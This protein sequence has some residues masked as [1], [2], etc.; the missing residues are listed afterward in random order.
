MRLRDRVAAIAGGGSGI[1][2]AC[3]LAFAREGANLAI[4]D[5]DEDSAAQVVA[6]VEALGRRAVARRLDVREPDQLAAFVEAAARQLGGLHVWVG[7]A[8]RTLGSTVLE[9]T[10]EDWR[11]L[12]CVNLDGVFFGA[13]AAARHMVEHG[14]GS[15]INL[16]SMYGLRAVPLR[17]AYC[18]SKAAVIMATQ[19]LAVELAEQKVRVNSIAPGYTDTPMLRG[20]LDRQARQVDQLLARVPMGRLASAEE[21]ADV[22]V[23]LAADESRFV[24][25][26]C[27]VADGAWAVAGG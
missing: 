6:E 9:Q 21:I 25:G 16:T 27:P 23:F 4:G 1:G 18:T 19:C 22:A 17:V 24:T 15:I 3:A 26:H 12:M 20:G 10:A 8:G 13:Q 11:Q 7:T 5:I 14:G 2:R